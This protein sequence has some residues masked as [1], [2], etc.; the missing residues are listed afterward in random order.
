MAVDGSGQLASAGPRASCC[1]G[2]SEAWGYTRL[3]ILVLTLSPSENFHLQALRWV[4]SIPQSYRDTLAVPQCPWKSRT[5]V[6]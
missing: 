5:V 4:G 6:A 3:E 1:A 2:R